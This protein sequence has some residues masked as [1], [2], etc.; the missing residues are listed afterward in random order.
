MVLCPF[1]L[2]LFPYIVWSCG[3]HFICTSRERKRKGKRWLVVFWTGS[4]KITGGGRLCGVV[5]LW[6]RW[7]KIHLF[8]RVLLRAFMWSHYRKF[9]PH[10]FPP[11]D[12][13]MEILYLLESSVIWCTHYSWEWAYIHNFRPK[14]LNLQTRPALMHLIWITATLV[15]GLVLLSSHPHSPDTS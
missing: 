10:N 1:V 9:W 7:R 8:V 6:M 13:A 12:G 2:Y 5:D 11:K 15:L 14:I 4:N 3:W